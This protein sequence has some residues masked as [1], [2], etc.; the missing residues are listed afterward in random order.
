MFT[1]WAFEFRYPG[2]DHE[3]PD[4]PTETELRAAMAVIDCLADCLRACIPPEPGA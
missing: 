2:P 3:M 4:E 1:S